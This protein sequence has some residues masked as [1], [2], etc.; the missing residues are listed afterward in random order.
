MKN[1]NEKLVYSLRILISALFFLSAFGK[2]YPTPLYGIT[3]VF[4]QGQLIPMGISVEA[5]AFLS[6]FN[7]F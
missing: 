3:K 4:E 7:L 1:N 2:L 6:R 5:S